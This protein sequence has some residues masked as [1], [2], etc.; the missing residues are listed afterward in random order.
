[1]KI[2]Y[3]IITAAAV[4]PLIIGFIWYGPL[5]FKNAWMKE[6][7]FTEESMKGAN[8][9]LIFGL[10]FVF[11]FLLSITLQT[12]VI[13]QWG[14][15]STLMGEP[16]FTEQTGDAFAYF[17]NFMETYGGRF[18]TFKHGAL[19]GTL[20]GLFVGLP[21][22]GTN[23]LFERKSVKYVAINVG[24]WVVTLALMGGVICQWA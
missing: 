1:M 22:M 19:H 18:R 9:A 4:I 11:S 12:L 14:V 24:Y 13:H 3:L 10:A 8:M 16:G 6:M 5:L 21:I 17:T 23:A 7:N 2:D 20:I 15:A